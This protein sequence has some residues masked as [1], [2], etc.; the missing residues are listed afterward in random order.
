MFKVTAH[1]EHFVSTGIACS[2]GDQLHPYLETKYQSS[3]SVRTWN[4]QGLVCRVFVH[5]SKASNKVCS[6]MDPIGDGDG[7][8]NR[9]LSLS[10]FKSERSHR[11]KVR[12]KKKPDL[13]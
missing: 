8:I 13:I 2:Y 1:I 9:P 12:P 3:S 6:V 4:V 11:E 10:N 7:G 5:E